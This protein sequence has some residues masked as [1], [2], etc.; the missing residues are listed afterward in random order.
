MDKNTENQVYH[1]DITRNVELAIGAANSLLAIGGTDLEIDEITYSRIVY[2]VAEHQ[3]SC[4]E[5]ALDYMK[6]ID[7]DQEAATA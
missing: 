5:I 7:F 1:E 4:L 3:K 2:A 6:K